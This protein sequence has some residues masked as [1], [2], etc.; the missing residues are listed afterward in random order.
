MR[1]PFNRKNKPRCEKD[2]GGVFACEALTGGCLIIKQLL[3]V[4]RNS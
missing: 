4:W 3:N 2:R 1:Q